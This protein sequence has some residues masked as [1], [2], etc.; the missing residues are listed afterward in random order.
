M[1][2]RRRLFLLWLVLWVALCACS[3]CSLPVALPLY[4][5]ILPSVP[6][7]LLGSEVP[8]RIIAI[9][10][11]QSG[12]VVAATS[13][14]GFHVDTSS[15]DG[16]SIT[17]RY[18][19]SQDQSQLGTTALCTEVGDNVKVSQMIPVLYRKDSPGVI[20]LAKDL[21]VYRGMLAMA[22]AILGLI[23]LPALGLFL[24]ICRARLSQPAMSEPVSLQ[25]E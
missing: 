22:A 19:D 12:P 8:G 23:V 5:S 10:T 6:L 18:T 17:V 14:G 11:C 16:V 15:S 3:C 21:G 25:L 1:K 20:I 7:V 13:G 2:P 9:H 24:R 4:S